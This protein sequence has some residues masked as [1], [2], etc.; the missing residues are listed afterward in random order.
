MTSKYLCPGLGH[1]H[2]ALIDHLH[3]SL[4]TFVLIVAIF[5]KDNGTD[6]TGQ[7]A[8]QVEGIIYGCS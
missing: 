2:K 3:K 5:S 7:V 8:A 6:V 1:L 4:E